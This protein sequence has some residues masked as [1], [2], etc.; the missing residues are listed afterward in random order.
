M[1]PSWTVVML[2]QRQYHL[3]FFTEQIVMTAF[4]EMNLSMGN[5]CD[6]SSKYQK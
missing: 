3:N 2:K 5:L 6:G 1:V 4:A